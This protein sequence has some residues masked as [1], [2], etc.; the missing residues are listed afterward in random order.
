MSSTFGRKI[1]QKGSHGRVA[2][3]N[4]HVQYNC[5]TY[6]RETPQKGVTRWG[7]SYAYMYNICVVLLAGNL[8]K[9][10]HTVGLLRSIHVYNICVALSAGK[11]P[12]K[13]SHLRLD[14]IQGFH[15][16]V[17]IP[18]KAIPTWPNIYSDTRWPYNEVYLPV[19][20]LRHT[21][22]IDMK[23]WVFDFKN[24]HETKILGLPTSPCV[25]R[26]CGH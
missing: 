3:L 8:P 26:F 17:A 11:P 16:A 22:S 6:G 4:T 7:C 2:Q 1:P 15:H 18:C 20:L 23:T 12:Q 21:M 19:F 25:K 14:S 10:G 9:R 13:G 24:R 5:S